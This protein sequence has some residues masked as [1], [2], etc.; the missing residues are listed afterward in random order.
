MLSSSKVPWNSV[1]SAA[2][3]GRSGRW[4]SGGSSSMSRLSGMEAVPS[5][6]RS[7]ELV[8][9][10]RV[11]LFHVVVDGSNIVEQE[12]T[13]EDRMIR[14]RLDGRAFQRREILGFVEIR[15]VEGELQSGHG[16]FH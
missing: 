14:R 10:R 9:Q 11:A 8:E 4:S 16:Y 6:G 12:A 7:E 15:Y 3:A 5:A 13:P 2:R 1:S